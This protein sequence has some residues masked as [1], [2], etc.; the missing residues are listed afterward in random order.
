MNNWTLKEKLLGTIGVTLVALLLVCGF[1]FWGLAQLNLVA[2]HAFKRMN[3]AIDAQGIIVNALK[4]YQNQADTIINEKTDGKDFAASSQALVLAVKKFGEIADTA[5]EKARVREM[6]S[7]LERLSELYTKEILPRVKQELASGDA[8]E[9]QRVREE[10]RLLDD[11]TDEQIEKLTDSAEKAIASLVSEANHE[12]TSHGRLASGIKV[13]MLAIS[14]IA[15]AAGLGLGLWIV[16]GITRTV[17]GITE[18]LAAGSE[19]T[20]A[21][22]HQVS[23]ASQSLAEGASEQAA[24]LEETS[25]SLEEMSSMTKQNAEHARK[26][27][28]L[29]KQARQA[30]DLGAQNVTTLNAAMGAIKTSS[31][32]IAKI[33]KTIDE[34]AFQTNILALN[35]AVEAARAGDAGMGFAVVAEEVR[36]LAQRSAQAAR[37]TAAKIEGAIANTAQGV[38]VSAQVG[39]GLTEIAAQARQV[40][41]LVAEVAVASQEQNQ[42]IE[43]LNVAVSQMDKVTQA[44]A[45]SAEESASAAEELRAQAEG[46]KE[47][48]GQLQTLVG[49]SAS[50]AA[51]SPK[52]R[53]P[54]PEVPV[55]HPPARPVKTLANGTP[56][57]TPHPGTSD[58]SGERSTRPSAPGDFKDF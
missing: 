55:K 44:N 13:K 26:A 58:A 7:G 53:P 18:R 6:Q 1:A 56:R 28:E 43:Q 21:A 54:Q 8:V 52:P 29:A 30:A 10:I 22:A 5:D 32:E 41:E 3:D 15:V 48:M 37:E 12:Q 38:A 20:S 25:S 33:I 57:E 34:I 45:A 47:T 46:M 16:R 40:D 42:G 39:Q 49:A 27:K 35:A 4:V 31:D 51:A 36:N 19:Q 14:V 2:N 9:K 24:S 17:R 11:R 23:A 50:L